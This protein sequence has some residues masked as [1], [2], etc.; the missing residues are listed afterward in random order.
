[1]IPRDAPVTT[2]NIAGAHLSSRRYVYSVPML[3][4]AEWALIDRTE[5]WV[6]RP[7][8]PI[9]T[10]H[11]KVVRR[12]VARLERD[13]GWTEGLRARRRLRLPAPGRLRLSLSGVR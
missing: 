3:E 8:S 12:L 11:P 2:S 13:A 5:P 7:D 6:A 9:L 1:M 10:K 4:R